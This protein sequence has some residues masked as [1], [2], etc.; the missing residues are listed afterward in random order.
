[1]ATNSQFDVNS[2]LQ[3]RNPGTRVYSLLASNLQC[4]SEPIGLRKRKR[5]CYVRSCLVLS[6]AECLPQLPSPG[7]PVADDNP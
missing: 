7:S 1:M 6:Y 3:V 2:L 4:L 5:S